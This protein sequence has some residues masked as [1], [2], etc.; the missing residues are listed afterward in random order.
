M[1]PP[2]GG[3]GLM[4]LLGRWREVRMEPLRA[5]GDPLGPQQEVLVAQ[6]PERLQRIPEGAEGSCGGAVPH[7]SG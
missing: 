5:G 2:G 4:K 1:L 7:G 3:E 6:S